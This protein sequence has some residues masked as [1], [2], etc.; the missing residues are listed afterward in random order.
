MWLQL[1]YRCVPS[2]SDGETV[3]RHLERHCLEAQ[4]FRL[5]FR[6]L[7]RLAQEEE[8]GRTGSDT[9]GRGRLG[10]MMSSI[11]DVAKLYDEF[12]EAFVDVMTAK[13][14][15]LSL[16]RRMKLRLARSRLRAHKDFTQREYD[17]GHFICGDSDLSAFSGDH[18]GEAIRHQ[19][20]MPFERW[21]SLALG[22]R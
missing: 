19:A 18:R 2:L 3:F 7:A 22:A 17:A 1:V 4:G 14:E 9:G 12:E 5:P 6:S 15:G 8:P 11:N 21:T 13:S 10:P 20:A 16:S